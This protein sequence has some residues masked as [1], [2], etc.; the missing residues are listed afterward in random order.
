MLMLNPKL[1]IL[2]EI[3][4]GLDVDS[5]KIVAS[6]VMNFMTKE[7]VIVIITHYPRILNYVKPNFVH[8]LFDGK[9][10]LS[11]DESLA[12][13]LEEKGYEKLLKEKGVKVD[14]EKLKIEEKKITAKDVI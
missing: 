6:A 5:L 1:V 4:S 12:S 11:G 7:K 14:G 2:D 9:I 3:D 8:I 13:E 10:V